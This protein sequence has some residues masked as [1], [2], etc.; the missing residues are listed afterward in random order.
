MQIVCK[1]TALNFA[2]MALSYPTVDLILDTRRRKA[3]GKFPVKLRLTYQRDQRYYKLKHDTEEDFWHEVE[4]GKRSKAHN[5]FRKIIEEIK[6]KATGVITGFEKKD[7]P[8]DFF[9]FQQTFFRDALESLKEREAAHD[10]ASAFQEYIGK[11]ER[12]GRPGTA[13]SYTFAIRSL[14]AFQSKLRFLDITPE[15]LEHYEAW[16]M[17]AGKSPT[18]IG[19]YLRSLRTIFNQALEREVITPKQYPFRKNRYQIPVTRNIKKALTRDEVDAIR[20]FKTTPGSPEDK[21]K[22]FWLF[23]YYCNGMNPKDI[24]QLC[25]RDVHGDKIVFIRAKTK[26]T[27]RSNPLPVVVFVTPPV[28]D[29][30]AVWGNKD[31]RPD[32]HLF[33]FLPEGLDPKQEMLVKNQFVK[34]VNKY[35]KRIGEAVG[36][37]KPLTTYVARHT[38]ATAMK[39]AGASTDF[40]SE[41]LGQS[42]PISTQHYLDSIDDSTKRQYANFLL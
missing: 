40:I 26:R 17:G 24:C 3:N 8:F 25:W 37:T 1:F 23:S 20:Q 27:T 6:A 15:W 16:M 32:S 22:S 12:Q 5:D 21:A 31:R 41:G 9:L 7:Q 42:N 34:T 33:P 4:Q 19:I 13:N 35:M 38:W 29:I 39:R 28:R 14:L 10:L 18:T 11:L 36:I 30:L 2:Y